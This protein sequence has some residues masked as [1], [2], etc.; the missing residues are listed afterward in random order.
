MKK[1]K[2][3]NRVFFSLANKNTILQLEAE[4]SN[5]QTWNKV[6]IFK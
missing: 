6:Q 4:A 1:K 2:F 5:I 3:G